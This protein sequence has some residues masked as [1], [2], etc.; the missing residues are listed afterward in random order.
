MVDIGV[1]HE[2]LGIDRGVPSASRVGAVC[3][4]VLLAVL[5]ALVTYALERGTTRALRWRAT[6]AAFT[7]TLLVLAVVVKIAH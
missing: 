3:I 6:A 4:G 5:I 7:A 2:L 1:V